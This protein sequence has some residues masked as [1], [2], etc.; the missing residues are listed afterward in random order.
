MKKKSVFG[1]EENIAGALSY[2]F[3][4]LSGILV[5]VLEK[6]NKYVRFHALQSTIWF[7]VL[8]LAIMLVDFVAGMFGL[9]PYVGGF[10][11]GLVGIVS[12]LGGLISLISLI[13]LMY[14]AFTGA[15]F[16]IPMIGDVVWGQVSK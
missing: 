5:L 11:G 14:K 6:D 15:L 2:L 9:L 10:L 16:K 3:G 13:F 7:L 12:G 8:W 4:P 1:L